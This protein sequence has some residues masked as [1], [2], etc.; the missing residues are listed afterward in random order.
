[1]WIPLAL[2]SAFTAALVAI[3]GKIGLQGVDPTLATTVRAVIMAAILVI[4]SAATGRWNA[5]GSIGNRAWLMI[6][7]AG[8]AGAASWLAY[9]LALRTGPATGVAALDRLSVV[10]VIILAALFLGE[11]LTWRLALGG[12]LM[13][14]GALL[15]VVR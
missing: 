2:L 1:M 6:V 13:T 7:L 12:A 4:V 15:M 9:F 8:A 14:A 5:L 3:F 10:F 11:T